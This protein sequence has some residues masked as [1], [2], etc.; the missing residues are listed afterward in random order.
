MDDLEKEHCRDIWR[1]KSKCKNPKDCV[2]HD[3]IPISWTLSAQSKHV[4]VLMCRKC[5]HEIN[6]SEAYAHR[7]ID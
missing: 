1:V 3:L 2:E 7:Q 5:F 6:I 4:T